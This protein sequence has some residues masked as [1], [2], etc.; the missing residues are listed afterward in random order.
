MI[1]GQSRSRQQGMTLLGFLIVGAFVGLFILAG[2]KLVPVYMEYAKIQATLEKVRDE[3]AGEKP[4]I[5]Q[6][7][8]AIER[9]FDIESVTSLTA[10][11]IQITRV[12]GGFEMRATYD[13]RTSYLGNLFLVAEFDTAVEVM[14]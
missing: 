12:E 8:Y 7:R 4:S 5:E 10:R 11:D 13:G 14:R 3:Y 1:H 9:H 2:I 6:I